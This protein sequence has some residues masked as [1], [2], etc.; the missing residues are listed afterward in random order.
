MEQPLKQRLIGAIILISLAV[1]FLP[2]FIGNKP[3]DAEIVAIEIPAA[4]KDLA[5]KIVALPEA[6]IE[7]LAEVTISKESGAKV[8]QIAQPIIPKPPKLK[9]VE[10]ITAWVIQVGSFS[11]EKNANA[12]SAKLMKA[13]FTAFVEQSAGK[14]GVVYRVRVGPE[15]SKEKAEAMSA[16]L[17]KEQKL[18]NA[19]V[20]QYP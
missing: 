8:V 20:V 10:G 18:V 4:P 15:L 19:I 1:I 11:A 12:L 3:T 2:M 16:K 17:Q 14:K 9:T 5:S 13:G 7:A 6:E